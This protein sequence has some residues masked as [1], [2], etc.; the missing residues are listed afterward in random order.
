MSSLILCF[1]APWKCFYRQSKL[2]INGK[3]GYTA[4]NTNR[5]N[6]WDNQNFLS[7]QILSNLEMSMRCIT[8]FIFKFCFV[9]YMV[10]F[11]LI[12]L[13]FDSRYVDKN[14]IC[15]ILI[16]LYNNIILTIKNRKKFHC[17]NN[18]IDVLQK[19]FPKTLSYL[20][21]CCKLFYIPCK[22]IWWE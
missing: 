1:E 5:I 10:A 9:R 16:Y 2:I 11:S 7:T 18:S 8:Y 12:I 19:L 21:F 4:T 17:N 15:R 22:C 14:R 6:V 13:L 20:T 3:D